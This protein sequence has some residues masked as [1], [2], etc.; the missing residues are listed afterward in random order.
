[1]RDDKNCISKEIEADTSMIEK[2]SK[3][4]K[5][6]REDQNITQEKFYIATNIHI[7]RI[8]TGKV[9]ITI[10]TLCEICDF[11]KISLKEFFH[12]FDNK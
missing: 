3:K 8:E 2:I 6:L 11:F 4:I 10:N 7:G 9:N 12:D 5:I 1:M